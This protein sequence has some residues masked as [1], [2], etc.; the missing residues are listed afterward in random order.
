MRSDDHLSDETLSALID[1]QLS[2]DDTS[3]SQVHLGTCSACALR[4]DELRSVA[5]LLR[6]LPELEAPRDFALGPRVVADPPNVI[7]LQRWY[8]VTRAAAASLAAVFVFLAAGALYVDS[9]PVPRAATTSAADARSSLSAPA[10]AAEPQNVPPAAP[11]PALSRAAAPAAQAPVGAAAVRS[12]SPGPAGAESD[13][14]AA[15]TSV[16][17]LPTLAPTPAPTAV[18]LPPQPP[19]APAEVDPAAPLRTAAAVVGVLA[20]L[21]LLATF[22]V[23]H[24]VR[25]AVNV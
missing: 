25:R 16:R 24:R 13:Q 8:A 11:T 21:T 5:E 3:A 1:N 17:P 14:V 22:L 7:R 19:P 4:R 18:A 12:A 6:S 10:P 20:V 2:S 9:Q 15:A 23:A